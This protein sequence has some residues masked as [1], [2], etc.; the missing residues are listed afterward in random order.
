MSLF[1]SLKTLFEFRLICNDLVPHS[2]IKTVAYKHMQMLLAL[3]LNLFRKFCKAQTL[4]TLAAPA[5]K[6]R[7]FDE[8]YKCSA[9]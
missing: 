2:A 3:P 5:I 4:L 8:I 1:D 9:P 7:K 6:C